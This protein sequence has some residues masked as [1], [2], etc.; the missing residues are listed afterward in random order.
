MDKMSFLSFLGE[1]SSFFIRSFIRTY[2][3]FIS[4]F[5]SFCLSA[6]PSHSHW[7]MVV[8]FS[9]QKNSISIREANQFV[10]FD[11]VTCSILLFA[12]V[13]ID[14]L[15]LPAYQP[16]GVNDYLCACVYA[17]VC[18]LYIMTLYIIFK[19]K[20][21]DILHCEWCVCCSKKKQKATINMLLHC[22][23]YHIKQRINM[24]LGINI[25]INI[26]VNIDI[27]MNYLG[28]IYIPVST[29][30]F[31]ISFATHCWQCW[32]SVSSHKNVGAF[33]VQSCQKEKQHK[34]TDNFID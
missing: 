17:Y 10:N 31:T 16:T 32:N 15:G 9:I 22:S 34:M 19:H 20:Y 13:A 27:N 29:Q 25:N 33:K 7:F 12:F 6:S 18:I 14:I 24:N 3:V 8:N 4:L 30:Y 23:K 5:F 11:H 1:N 28:S 21:A 26:N 2:R